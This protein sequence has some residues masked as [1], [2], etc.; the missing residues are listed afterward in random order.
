M[1]RAASDEINCAGNV[2]PSSST[3]AMRFDPSMT[4]SFVRMWPCESTMNPD[5]D[6]E[7]ARTCTTPVLTRSTR[8]GMDRSALGVGGLVVV[9]YG[10][11]VFLW[12]VTGVR[13][14]VFL[15]MVV[16]VRV[17]LLAVGE[18]SSWKA[19]ATAVR[20]AATAVAS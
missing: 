18:G 20:A 13:V 8:S 12:T 10:V 11:G 1:S 15:W 4:C 9:G 7:V 5:P 17:L 6:P 2:E 19:R 14:G 3:T 16:G